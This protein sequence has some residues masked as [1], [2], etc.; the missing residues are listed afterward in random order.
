MQLTFVENHQWSDKVSDSRAGYDWNMLRY[1][2]QCHFSGV[3]INTIYARPH[4]CECK[5]HRNKPRLDTKTYRQILHPLACG[6]AHCG[7][8][9]I[10]AFSK[11]GHSHDLPF[12]GTF[13]A[14]LI[15]LQTHFKRS[16][17]CVVHAKNA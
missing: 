6:T 2:L 15:M 12:Q 3:K 4:I 10:L 7:G 17:H 1:R 9:C 5:V 8:S 13:Y 11:K 14:R 16:I